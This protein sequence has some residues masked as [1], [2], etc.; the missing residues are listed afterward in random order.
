MKKIY[1]DQLMQCMI[2]F[3]IKYTASVE[4]CKELQ[5]SDVRKG[6]EL[7]CAQDLIHEILLQYYYYYYSYYQL[8]N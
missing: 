5:H 7:Q 1:H 8:L 3:I 2:I 4:D 6:V